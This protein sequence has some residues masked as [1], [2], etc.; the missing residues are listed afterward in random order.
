M[1]R[2]RFHNRKTVLWNIRFSQGVC[3]RSLLASLFLLAAAIPASAEATCDLPTFAKKFYAAA[4]LRPV[5]DEPW[6]QQCV[7][8]GSQAFSQWSTLES[9]A[10]D[11]NRY[12]L[13]IENISQTYN[14]LRID[15][16]GVSAGIRVFRNKDDLITDIESPQITSIAAPLPK[17]LAQLGELPG[18]VTVLVERD[19]KEIA[20][21]SPGLPLQVSSSMKLGILRTLLDL[22]DQG[23]LKLQNNALVRPDLKALPSGSLHQ[24]ADYAPV[25]LHSLASLM[26]R[27]SDNTAADVLIDT[28]GKDKIAETL[29]LPYLMTY[30]QWFM[31]KAD[32]DQYEKFA[33]LDDKG[34]KEFLAAMVPAVPL[35]YANS[36]GGITPAAGWHVSNFKLCEL[37]ERVAHSPFAQLESAFLEYDEWRA[38]AS[39]AGGDQTSRNDTLMLTRNDGAKFC[40]SVTWNTEDSI[41]DDS[42]YVFLVMSLIEAVRRL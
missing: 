36:V 38:V 5:R 26:M 4:G 23:T 12:G 22:V 24:F 19:G 11:A 14:T 28:I 15:A 17:L 13:R 39:K 9:Y 21:R 3:M 2:R 1:R 30:H 31:L 18:D 16:G 20:S 42:R 35:N 27:D 10:A 37:A 34:R 8:A 40:V 7:L 32:L 6:F 25:T 41:T 29:G 33:K